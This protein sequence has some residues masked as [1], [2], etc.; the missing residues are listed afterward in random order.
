MTGAQ[1]FIRP[2]SKIRQES[3]R[4]SRPFSYLFIVFFA[5]LTGLLGLLMSR[6]GAPLYT[7]IVTLILGR[8]LSLL[9]AHPYYAF[10]AI[11][12]F[13]ILFVMVLCG[14]FYVAARFSNRK[15]T[16][17]KM[18]DLVS[19]SLV[20]PVA[21]EVFLLITILLGSRGSL[22]LIIVSILLMS[23]THLLSFRSALALTE[24][25]VFFFLMFVYISS[26][27]FLS[28]LLSVGVRILIA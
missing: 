8:G 14:A 23:I 4:V 25:A 12:G 19:L 5:L 11:T 18:V 6:S 3:L 1:Y 2:A 24:D 26:Y 27:L 22:S 7:T 16:F 21:M 9:Y 20:Y 28:V 17:R 10:A 13:S 15:P